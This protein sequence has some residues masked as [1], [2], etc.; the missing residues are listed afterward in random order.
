MFFLKDE[1]DG[2]LLVYMALLFGMLG[3]L[4]LLESMPAV[5]RRT[6][7]MVAVLLSDGRRRVPPRVLPTPM[8]HP[9]PVRRPTH[10]RL[11]S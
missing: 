3:L 9:R 2:M 7:R 6:N 11:A 5:R 4:A 8:A 10:S 1:V